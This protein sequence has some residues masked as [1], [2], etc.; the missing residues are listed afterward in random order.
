M[1]PLLILGLAVAQV[2]AIGPGD[3]SRKLTIEGQERTYLVHV[4]KGYDGTKPYPVVL[5]FHG[6]G[7]NARQWIP[8]CGINE[9][10][11]QAHFVAVYPNG[12]GKTI[13]YEGE[14]YEVFGWNGGPRQP[15]G[16]TKIDDVAFTRAVLDDLSK[17]VNVDAKRV[18]ATGMSMGAIMAY[19]LAGELSDRIAA[20]AP[21]AGPMGTEYC[22]P[23][24]P[25]SVLHIHGTEDDAVPFTGGKG[26]LDPSGADFYSAEHSIRAWVKANGC[27]EQ[28]TTDELPDT[29]DD[30]TKAVRKTYRC[31]RDGAEVVLIVVQGG[32]HTWPGRE[33]GPELKM[34][35]KSSKDFS[36]NDLI[37]QFFK[38]HPKQ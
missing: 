28:P 38:K 2:D 14:V 37:W 4:P 10:A 31:V 29:A 13:H 21:I 11:D 30:G 5:V 1:L 16:E 9:K 3:Y 27:D 36:A 8:F 20:I 15:G 25:V 26:K 35:G 17:V 19:R 18:Y 23:K 34:L 33:F 6:G 22:D 24:Q 7:N 32:G 12:T